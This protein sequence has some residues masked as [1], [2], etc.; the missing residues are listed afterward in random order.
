MLGRVASAR[1]EY[2][3]ALESDPNC[4][5]CM[6]D[7]ADLNFYGGQFES[8]LRW[9]RRA[10]LLA[11]NTTNGYYHVAGALYYFGDA[12]FTNQ[13]LSLY[14]DK[15]PRNQPFEYRFALLLEEGRIQEAVTQAV[16]SARARP[17]FLQYETV[18]AE[19][20]AGAPEAERLTEPI[21]RR[22]PEPLYGQWALV[23][24]SSR[25][26]YACLLLKR[27]ARALAMPLLAASEKAI[28]KMLAEGADT[29]M[30]H[31]ELA[32]IHALRGEKEAALTEYERAYT[33]GWRFLTQTRLNPALESLR[34]EPKFQTLL[35]RMKA[36]LAMM[37]T[38]SKELVELRERTIP[39]LRSLPTASPK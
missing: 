1:T 26:R 39:Y 2:E 34:D 35:E 33:A 3:K 19:T 22:A 15:F 12:E 25:T 21:F 18:A 23:P 20:T 30:A 37:R 32:A 17:G 38:E 27:G 5:R 7:L 31:E 24:E 4:T 11:P 36:D 16:N 13:F 8:A 6:N 29:S 28:R 14:H 9:S 10:L